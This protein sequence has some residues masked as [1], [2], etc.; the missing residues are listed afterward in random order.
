MAAKFGDS[1]SNQN[2]PAHFVMDNEQM[3]ERRSTA[4][5]SHRIRRNAHQT[6]LK[7]VAVK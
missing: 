1:R 5:E 2:Q 6:R 3:N 4:G 7:N